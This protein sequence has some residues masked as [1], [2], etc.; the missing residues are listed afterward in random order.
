MDKYDGIIGGFMMAFFSTII[1]HIIFSD[2]FHINPLAQKAEP[3]KQQIIFYKNL[4]HIKN[5]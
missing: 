1:L 3:L 2:Q 5:E 4:D